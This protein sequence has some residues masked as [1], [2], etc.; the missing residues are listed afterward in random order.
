[1]IIAT[2]YKIIDGEKHVEIDEISLMREKRERV[3][4]I[5][6][7]RERERE[8]EASMSSFNR[9]SRPLLQKTRS[10]CLIFVRPA[11]FPIPTYFTS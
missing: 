10:S 8:G 1:M 2:V 5:Y 11:L 9:H 4:Y 7:H 3:G 6:I